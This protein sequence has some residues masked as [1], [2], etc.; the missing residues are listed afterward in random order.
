MVQP[1]PQKSYHLV[2]EILKEMD[3]ET[4]YEKY[5]VLPEMSK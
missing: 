3:Y 2:E 4:Q 5:K 1:L